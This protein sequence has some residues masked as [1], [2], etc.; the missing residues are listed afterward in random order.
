MLSVNSYLT[1]LPGR[2]G[3]KYRMECYVHAAGY[4]TLCGLPVEGLSVCGGY[5]G[6]G[7]GQVLVMVT[8]QGI[9]GGSIISLHGCASECG[10]PRHT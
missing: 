1:G 6:G 10:S 4:V 5:Y 2:G 8:P 9:A 7:E 3:W